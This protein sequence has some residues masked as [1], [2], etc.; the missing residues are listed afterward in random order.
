MTAPDISR[1]P[2]SLSDPDPRGCYLNGSS[3]LQHISPDGNPTSVTDKS[4]SDGE[5]TC[6]S[7]G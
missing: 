1:M 2:V 6:S 7:Q 3:S 5:L 4:P